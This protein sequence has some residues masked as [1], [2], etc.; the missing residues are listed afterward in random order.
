MSTT[1]A[2]T[3]YQLTM[4]GGVTG[5]ARVSVSLTIP[6]S[7][8]FTDAEMTTLVNGLLAAFPAAWNVNAATN[9]TKTVQ[10]STTYSAALSGAATMGEF[11]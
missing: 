7:D 2:G 9:V 10:N 11:A 1:V 6:A 8:S 5:G 3:Q 4:T